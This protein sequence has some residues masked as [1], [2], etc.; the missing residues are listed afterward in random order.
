MG[1]EQE[2]IVLSKT[3]MKQE[4]HN[5]QDI[6]KRLTTL[7]KEERAKLHLPDSLE[8]AIQDYSKIQSNGANRRQL[9]FI[10]RLMRDLP[11]ENVQIILTY[12]SIIDGNNQSHN[13]YIK[14]LERLREELI[15]EENALTTYLNQHP[16]IE[17]TYLRTLIRNCKKE[18]ANNKP[19][20]AYREIFKFLKE[21]EP[22]DYQA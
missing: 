10:G 5:L 13:A 19:P 18:L 17:A 2:E 16:D 22:F 12:F 14:R 21:V 8:D 3:K 20:R 11:E 1:N 4:M 6:G 9:Q 15:N 7:S